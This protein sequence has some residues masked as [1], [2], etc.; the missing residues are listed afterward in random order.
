MNVLNPLRQLYP[1]YMLDVEHGNTTSAIAGLC[2][3]LILILLQP[4]GIEL[5]PW[6]ERFKDALIFGS[7]SAVYCKI[8]LLV[9]SF[10]L[11]KQFVKE[12]KWTIGN[13]I[14][15]QIWF[16]FSLGIINWITGHYIFGCDFKLSFFIRWQRETFSVGI[17][18][19]LALI[20]IRQI[21]LLKKYSTSANTLEAKLSIAPMRAIPSAPKVNGLISFSDDSAND[22]IPIHPADI[23]YIVAADNYIRI[24][25]NQNNT[26]KTVLIRSTLKRAEEKLSGYDTF[27]RC[28][29]SYLVNL[30]YIRHISGNAAGYKLHLE[31]LD[32]LIPVSRN[33]NNEISEKINT[34][35]VA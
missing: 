28:H 23:S 14:I 5:L 3:F 31:G 9:M 21:N 27:Y 8:K 16:L 17:F 26:N 11:K 10:L 18:P 34:I 12:E 7:I 22:S 19:V 2:V 6:D 29:R 24:N 35:L 33:L 25:Y 1:S 4:F 30:N 15:L 20:I 32:E 13:E